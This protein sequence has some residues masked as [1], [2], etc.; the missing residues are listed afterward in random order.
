MSGFSDHLS[1]YLSKG[2]DESHLNFN[3]GFGTNL[4]PFMDAAKEAGHNISIYSGY[5]S[6]EHQGR[7]YQDALEKY[8]SPAAA[9]KWVAPPGKSQH[10]HGTAAAEEAEED[11]HRAIDDAQP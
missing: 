1:G 11:S 9:R 7:L 2:K 5:R 6:D 8:G 4:V 3:Q 10:N